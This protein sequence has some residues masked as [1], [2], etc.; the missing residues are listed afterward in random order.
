MQRMKDMMPRGLLLVSAGL[1]VWGVLGLVEY[2]VPA[3]DLGLQNNQFPAGLQFLHFFAL[4]MTGAVFCA[5]YLL[6]WRGTP[7]GTV[8][9]YAVLA[10]LCFIET[11]DFGAF[12]GGPLRF[13]PMAL[14]YA[15]YLA[16]SAYLLRSQTMRDFFGS[17]QVRPLSR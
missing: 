3:V 8:V 6:R 16:L 17:G 9:M 10:T 7:V 12:G 5:G 11:V 1:A 14:E 4:L 13:V 2:F 15:V